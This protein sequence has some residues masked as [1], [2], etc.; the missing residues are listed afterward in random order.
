MQF[1]RISIWVPVGILILLAV[2]QIIATQEH[3][4]FYYL[5]LDIPMHIAGGALITLVAF[6]YLSLI[7]I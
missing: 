2:V 6:M 1:R 7:H 5:W 4:Y 3:L